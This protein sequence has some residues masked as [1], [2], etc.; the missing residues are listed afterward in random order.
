MPGDTT[1]QTT[2]LNLVTR[3]FPPVGNA[4]MPLVCLLL[5]VIAVMFDNH[6]ELVADDCLNLEE[7]GTAMSAPRRSGS[8]ELVF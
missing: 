7:G 8:E 5:K 4:A 1:I 6:E 3:L 2:Y